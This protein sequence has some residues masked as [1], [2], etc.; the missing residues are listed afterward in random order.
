MSAAAVAAEPTGLEEI[1]SRLA[2]D[3]ERF[4]QPADS[5][6]S[7]LLTYD[8]R[9]PLE[10]ARRTLSEFTGEIL[11]LLKSGPVRRLTPEPTREEGTLQLRLWFDSHGKFWIRPED[12]PPLDYPQR[13]HYELG[14]LA[15]PAYL[16]EQLQNGLSVRLAREQRLR[17][18]MSALLERAE[19]DGTL[20]ELVD[21][22]EDSVRHVEAV[23]IFI[24]DALWSVMEG[25]ATLIDRSAGEGILPRLRRT[26]LSEWT[27]TE[28]FG[29]VAL[30]ALFLSGRSVRFEE[31]NGA[32]LSA[33]R[34][35]ERFRELSEGYA[36]CRAL[37]ATQDERDIFAWAKEIRA[38]AESSPGQAWLRYRWINGLTYVK[39]ER[40]AYIEPVQAVSRLPEPI[41]ELYENWLGE[42]YHP[43]LGY[44]EVFASLAKHALQGDAETSIQL[45]EGPAKS[46]VEA[47]IQ[48]IVAS[49]V[50]ESGADYGM[51]S[52]LRD[53]TP[54][55]AADHAEL[56]RQIHRLKPADFFTC[57]V[58][59]PEL[60][61]EYGPDFNR[62]VFAAIQRRMMFNRWHFIAGN[63]KESEVERSRHYFYPP[64]V[65]DL[66]EWSDQRHGGHVKAGVRYS[67]R[68][69][70]PDMG[71]A[72]LMIAG[73]PYRGFYDVR[74]A[75]A[76]GRP[77][78]V[79][80]LLLVRRHCLWL[81]VVW[82]EIIE[83]REQETS[84]FAV[85]GFQ[86]GDGLELEH[87]HRLGLPAPEFGRTRPGA[88]SGALGEAI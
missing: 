59:R 18:L 51:S 43:S 87:Q 72:P 1:L 55:L 23:S 57:V 29:V 67:V 41:A 83:A 65:P 44:R 58:A 30:R 74:V 77:F 48:A 24:D 32:H 35:V 70:G 50:M 31:F 56:I 10:Q 14:Y 38:G 2:S 21:A 40:C 13:E 33:V 22:V 75:R 47:L 7:R 3:P 79:R 73:R 85:R 8:A 86:P 9:M 28:R 88:L 15:L 69:P 80:D 60:A 42:P 6:L 20:G 61:Q 76:K 62:H 39:T 11:D 78:D 68:S 49:A 64:L 63:L 81:G 17:E 19:A 54:L 84:A 45:A 37:P 12:A 25:C 66:A 36:R 71:E 27:S 34:L 4:A 53:L 82:R 5:A 52:S 46:A 26:P 16:H